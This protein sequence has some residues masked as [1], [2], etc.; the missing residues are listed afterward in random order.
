MGRAGWRSVSMLRH[1]IENEPCAIRLPDGNSN[2]FVRW[3]S[4]CPSNRRLRPL[5][6][7][8]QRKL[9]QHLVELLL[10][11]GAF[12]RQAVQ[13]RAGRLQFVFLVV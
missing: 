2:E 11:V 10:L 9:L 3:L 12:P 6:T 4:L 1:H 13:L 5:D 7:F 8:V